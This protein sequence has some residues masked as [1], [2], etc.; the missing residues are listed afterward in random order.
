MTTANRPQSGG[1]PVQPWTAGVAPTGV[2]C[3]ACGLTNEAGARTC[4]NCGLP[5]AS[6][7]DPIRGVSPGRVDLPRTRR[8]GFSAAIGFVLVVALLLVGGSLAL[9]GGGGV[10]SGGGRLIGPAETPTP[11]PAAVTQTGTDGPDAPEVFLEEEDLPKATTANMSTYSCENGA[12]KDLSRGRWFLTDV[13]A[14][15]REEEDGTKYDQVYWRLDR[16][17][18]GKKVKAR[19]ATT[20]TMRWTTPDAAKERYGDVIGR[21]QG[22]RAI[23]IVFD[24]PVD[25]SANAVIEQYELE[26]VDIEQLRRVQMFEHAKKVR[27]LIG[28]K[29]DSCARLG[30]VQWGAKSTQDNARVVL[31]VERFD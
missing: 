3:P 16:Q 9:T 14:T 5:I 15:V 21:V 18:P 10:L 2:T 30:S 29:G 26:N 6:A 28:I 4:R 31:D 13:K 20:V 11:A 8:S 7:D 23:E 22:D 17:N 19:S 25:I 12:I 24:G 27:T 1:A